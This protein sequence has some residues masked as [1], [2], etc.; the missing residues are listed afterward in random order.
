MFFTNM[1]EVKADIQALRENPDVAAGAKR[2]RPLNVRKIAVIDLI[3]KIFVTIFCLGLG[4]YLFTSKGMSETE[5]K[6]GTFLIG[7][8]V[9]FWLK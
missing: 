7:A 4:T 2:D 1:R 9:G 5:K 3:M 6:F 8:A